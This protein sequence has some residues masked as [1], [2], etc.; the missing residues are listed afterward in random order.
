MGELIA[1]SPAYTDVKTQVDLAQPGD[2]VRI[3]HGAATWGKDNAT[4]LLNITTDIQLIGGY[5]GGG[6]SGMDE[7]NDPPSSA[8]ATIITVTHST[9]ACINA[10]YQNTEKTCQISGIV[11]EL[12]TSGTSYLIVVKGKSYRH[13][14]ALNNV[15]GGMRMDH[16]RFRNS[17]DT[18]P[19][20]TTVAQQ[21]LPAATIN[22][23]S[24]TG[25]PS[26]GGRITVGGQVVTYTGKTSNSFT[27]CTG[28]TGIIASG[29]VVS[30]INIGPLAL[31]VSWGGSVAASGAGTFIT[32]SFDHN[33]VDYIVGTSGSEVSSF[34]CA[35]SPTGAA[36]DGWGQYQW[37]QNYT[38][39][40][41]DDTE[42]N[43]V[44]IEDNIFHRK[45]YGLGSLSGGARFIC[46]Y[47]T[48]WG[49]LNGHGIDG[50]NMGP[51]SWEYYNNYFDDRGVLQ[52]APFTSTRGGSYV[53]FNNRF[54]SVNTNDIA[55]Q[56]YRQ[57]SS[58]SNTIGPATGRNF[59]DDN[60]TGTIGP[61]SGGDGV[62]T[63][64]PIRGGAIKDE[65]NDARLGSVYAQGTVNTVN[66]PGKNYKLNGLD[67]T[68][69]T[70]AWKDFIIVNTSVGGDGSNGDQGKVSVSNGQYAGYIT[71]S[72]NL[73]P[74]TVTVAGGANQNFNLGAGQNWEIRRVR[75]YLCNPGSGK[76]PLVSNGGFNQTDTVNTDQTG[77]AY[78]VANGSGKHK[79]WSSQPGFG[80]F[81][82]Y[83]LTR[84]HS[85]VAWNDPAVIT[86]SIKGTLSEIN[87][88]GGCYDGQLPGY[89]KNDASGSGTG[90][91]YPTRTNTSDSIRVGA[92]WDAP[93]YTEGINQGQTG[94]PTQAYGAAWPNAMVGG[95]VI[96]KPV[97][98]SAAT[99][100]ATVSTPFTYNITASNGP[101][102]YGIGNVPLPSG[103]SVNSTTG[104]ISGTPDGQPGTYPIQ[105][106]A[107]NTGGT[108][109]GPLVITL[110]GLGSGKRGKGVARRVGAGSRRM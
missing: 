99:A 25:Y 108:G 97:I 15:V 100:S 74:C 45:G 30:W 26:T 52:S 39:G 13:R 50:G 67:G 34:G 89:R 62:S 8:N 105:I 10:T 80:L 31:L 23:G 33:F 55:S 98:T 19:D 70:N 58:Q 106:T 17:I 38:F 28:G 60:Y 49:G 71:S 85:S 73:N 16:V 110:S 103:L 1:A 20:T 40:G 43:V 7:G 44:Y 94:A 79:Y 14:D 11:F 109:T 82:A 3:P 96:T 41:G 6:L 61:F 35:G 22:V 18:A 54:T 59:L 95:T 64:A 42:L 51:A 83:N 46:R 88:S 72:N 63:F 47:N 81:Q 32:G 84:L 101:T 86:P 9:G 65:T 48:S 78:Q 21:T 104:V 56:T 75:T 93:G 57:Y 90:N 24:T 102:S 29:S 5:L 87:T 68:I 27:G 53:I 91:P 69:G 92:H 37:E 66:T 36:P 76:V 4:G 107:S 12:T 77:F 2:T